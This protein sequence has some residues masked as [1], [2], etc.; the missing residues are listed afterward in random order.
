MKKLTSISLPQAKFLESVFKDYLFMLNI[1]NE[2]VIDFKY[3]MQMQ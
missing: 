3:A 2:Q 1:V